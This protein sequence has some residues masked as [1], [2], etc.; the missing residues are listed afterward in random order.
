MFWVG[1]QRWV[2]HSV[3]GTMRG[4]LVLWSFPTLVRPAVPQGAGGSPPPPGGRG[5]AALSDSCPSSVSSRCPGPHGQCSHR[6]ENKLRPCNYAAG[7][8]LKYS[9]S[10]R[11]PF[12]ILIITFPALIP[13]SAVFPLFP[14]LPPLLLLVLCPSLGCSL[15]SDLRWTLAVTGL[16]FQRSPVAVVTWLHPLG[17][18]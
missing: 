1:G 2:L 9:L 10:G 7:L 15:C 6:K 3:T 5:A 4:H 13:S 18:C 11:A 17:L 12:R 16:T 14:S 8:V